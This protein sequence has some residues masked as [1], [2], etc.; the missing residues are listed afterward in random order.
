MRVR[1]F[2]VGVLV[3]GAVGAVVALVTFSLSSDG[4]HRVAIPHGGGPVEAAAATPPVVGCATRAEPSVRR[5]TRQ[6]D[7]IRGPFALVTVARGLPRLSRRSYRPRDG[8]LPSIKLPVGLRAGHKATLSVAPNQRAYAALAYREETRDAR[9]I[10]Q[11]HEA[12][13]FKPCP[14]DTPAFHGGGTVGTITG[15]AGALIITGPRCIRLQLRVDGKRR[16]DIKLPLGRR[17]H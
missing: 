6:R 10:E 15:W 2:L 5:F 17:C 1:T 16:P 13:A 8:R 12:V 7:V 14:A 3:L 4:E 11:G 9:R